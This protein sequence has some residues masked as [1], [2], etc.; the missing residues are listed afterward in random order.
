MNDVAILIAAY[1]TT[2]ANAREGYGAL[3]REIAAAF[4]G[5]PIAWSFTSAKV[6]EKVA[7]A[8]SPAASPAEA[9]AALR[10][11]GVRRVAVQSLHV[12]PGQEFAGTVAAC[13]EMQGGPDPFTAVEIGGPLLDTPEDVAAAAA[14][15]PGFL[16][17]E[18]APDE[19]VVLVGHG[20]EAGGDAQYA[21]FLARARATD[22]LV[23]LGLLT[24]GPGP[25]E[26]AGE[27]RAEG[28]SR[29]WLLPFMCVPGFHAREDVA[30]TAPASWRSVFK[31]HGLHVRALTLGASGHPGF[32]AL[33]LG[34]LRAA[35]ER[36]A[37]A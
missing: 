12:I 27:L 37:R 3:A 23:R 30:G 20:S 8:G 31:S 28:V 4:P 16:P 34:H 2:A 17:A 24:G 5:I 33:W 15:L 9:L 14:A 25:G 6:R 35:I 19:A 1:G 36:L 18:R 21:G 29:V 26:L 32:R 11:S 13:R 10:T 22:P 7:C